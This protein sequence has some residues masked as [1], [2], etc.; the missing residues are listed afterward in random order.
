MKEDE[1]RLIASFMARVIVKKE[2]LAKVRQDVE[3]M[4]SSYQKVHYAFET[5][6]P[7]YKYVNVR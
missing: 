4:R 6:T 1:M 7:A 3:H 5:N 2:D